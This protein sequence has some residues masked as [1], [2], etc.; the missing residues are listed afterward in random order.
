[1]NCAQF[2]KKKE[3]KRKF[4]RFVKIVRNEN[5][6]KEFQQKDNRVIR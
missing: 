5:L 4:L 3:R 1:M 6:I 2:S